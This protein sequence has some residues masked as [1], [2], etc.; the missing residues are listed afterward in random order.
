M[1]AEAKVDGETGVV[2]IYKRYRF[3][4]QESEQANES[5]SL[6]QKGPKV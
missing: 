5:Q 6:A 2:D 4:R 3:V 1:K